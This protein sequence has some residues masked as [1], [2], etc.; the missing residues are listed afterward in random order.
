MLAGHISKIANKQNPTTRQI[1]T[2][3]DSACINHS[4]GE[5][6]LLITPLNASSHPKDKPGG[7]GKPPSPRHAI[8]SPRRSNPP[9]P[10]RKRQFIDARLY[11][12][13]EKNGLFG[14]IHPNLPK[15]RAKRLQHRRLIKRPRTRQPAITQRSPLL[16][17]PHLIPLFPRQNRGGIAAPRPMLRVRCDQ[18]IQPRR[19]IRLFHHPNQRRRHARPIGNRQRNRLFRG[20]GEGTPPFVWWQLREYDKHDKQAESAPPHPHREWNAHKKCRHPLSETTLKKAK[21]PPQPPP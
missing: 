3:H 21:D 7:K 14:R 16:Q 12:H 5:K 17:R 19:G 20:E 15:D 11:P 9:N 10:P 13:A 8:Q 2:G 18:P 1:A 6:N 4:N